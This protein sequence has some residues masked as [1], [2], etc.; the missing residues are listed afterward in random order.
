MRKWIVARGRAWACLLLLAAFAAPARSAAQDLDSRARER[1]YYE[2]KPAVVMVVTT[3]QGTVTILGET[4]SNAG[5]AA[6]GDLVIVGQVVELSAAG[7]GFIVSPDGYVVTNGHVVQWFHEANEDQLKSMLLYSALDNAGYFAL[8]AARRGGGVLTE[9]TKYRL[10]ERLL[11]HTQVTLSK[12]LDVYLQNWHSLPAEVKEYSAPIQ[13]FTGKFAVIGAN[14]TNGKDVAV[15]KVEGRDLPT[16]QVGDSQAMQ[17]GNAISVAGYPGVGTFLDVL[18]LN[19]PMQASFTR[20]QVSS[21]KVDVKGQSLLQVDAGI[22]F[23]N[24]GGPVINDQGLVVGMATLGAANTEAFNFAVPTNTI[25]EFVRSS[26]L[27]PS[28]GLFDQQWRAG[29]DHYYRGMDLTASRPAQAREAFQSSIASFDEVLRI[30][31]DLPDAV[32]LRQQAIRQRE[33]LPTSQPMNWLPWVIGGIVA[34]G[35]LLLIMGMMRR[36]GA[37]AVA[38]APAMAR[39]KNGRAAR[40]VVQAGPLMGNNFQVSGQGLKIGRDPA[41]CQVVLAEPTVSREHAMLYA[42]GTDSEFVLKNLSGTNATFV[43]DR[44]V[45]ETTLKHGDRIKIGNSV[46]VFEKT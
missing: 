20:G 21:L 4:W 17:I 9:D 25:N 45:Q 41:A 43:N 15:L 32:Y 38:G 6:P 33:A 29:L 37:G 22:S 14:L 13:P 26:G 27:T 39:S 18:N 28:A 40:L 11:P 19:T 7:S 1:L 23:G 2:V 16:M 34:I 31:P 10:M 44:A 24:S 35:L 3:I 30:L 36:K 42:S 8:E 46:I 5:L 12:D